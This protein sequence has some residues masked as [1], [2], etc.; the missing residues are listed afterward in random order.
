MD[1]TLLI[2]LL[3]AALPIASVMSYK[4]GRR[5]R[6]AR[7]DESI[8]ARETAQ[9]SLSAAQSAIA[10]ALSRMEWLLVDYPLAAGDYPKESVEKAIKRI[11]ELYTPIT[12][13]LEKSKQ[14]QLRGKQ[15]SPYLY[16]SNSTNL[17]KTAHKL[18][19]AVNHLNYRINDFEERNV[20]LSQQ[21]LQ[22]RIADLQ[23]RYVDF[24]T[25]F[26]TRMYKTQD[27]VRRNRSFKELAASVEDLEAKK[28]TIAASLTSGEVD[29]Y[30]VNQQ[31]DELHNDCRG[32]E[33]AHCRLDP[34]AI[35][36][37]SLGSM[38]IRNRL[39]HNKNIAAA[40]Q[41]GR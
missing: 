37:Y 13:L 28:R 39:L 11:E 40:L 15:T 35:L 12:E 33:E 8:N 3:T 27:P 4:L 18:N 19:D 29:R 16:E 41:K 23:R 38:N 6:Q 17:H 9:Q 7:Y 30:I 2:S 5:T 26:V 36:F 14:L 1:T 24:L 31:I 34:D 10:D 21:S 22:N 25:E 20:E 32:L